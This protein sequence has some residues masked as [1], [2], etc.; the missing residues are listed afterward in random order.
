MKMEMLISVLLA[1]IKRPLSRGNTYPSQKMI[2]FT[3]SVLCSEDD[4]F[5]YLL[6][7]FHVFWCKPLTDLLP[8]THQDQGH[9]KK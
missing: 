2:F 7:C 6:P 9:L 8:G 3:G 5:E 4:P 1:P